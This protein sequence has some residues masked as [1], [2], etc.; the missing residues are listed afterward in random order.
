MIC[1]VD[2]FPKLSTGGVAAGSSG[3]AEGMQAEQT[4]LSSTRAALRYGLGRLKQR[5]PLSA[6]ASEQHVRGG[7]RRRGKRHTASIHT[8]DS[9]SSGARLGRVAS[10]RRHRFA[11]A[12]P[13]KHDEYYRLPR[14][15]R[16]SSMFHLKVQYA[17]GGRRKGKGISSSVVVPTTSDDGNNDESY[18]RNNNQ[19]NRSIVIIAP[20]P[21]ALPTAK[22]DALQ[23]RGQ[24]VGNSTKRDSKD[25]I[26]SGRMGMDVTRPRRA[27]YVSGKAPPHSAPAVTMARAQNV[28]AA[29]GQQQQ[30]QQRGGASSAV[31]LGNNGRPYTV[32][33]VRPSFHYSQR[34]RPLTAAATISPQQATN[35]PQE[36]TAALQPF[37]FS[38][39][40]SSLLSS[41]TSDVHQQHQSLLQ[42]TFHLASPPLGNNN[43]IAAA[44]EAAQQH[45]QANALQTL[46]SGLQRSNT[47]LV[48]DRLSLIL[49]CRYC[50]A[51]HHPGKPKAAV[52]SPCSQC[53]ADPTMVI[54]RRANFVHTSAGPT[55]DIVGYFAAH[56]ANTAAMMAQ[57]Q[58]LGSQTASIPKVSFDSMPDSSM[59]SR[60]SDGSDGSLGS[61]GNML[62]SVVSSAT[63]GSSLMSQGARQAALS[64]S[65]VWY[66]S[67]DAPADS[68]PGMRIRLRQRSLVVPPAPPPT[69]HGPPAEE[70]EHRFDDDPAIPED[71]ADL[72]AE[73]RGTTT[74]DDSG[75]GSSQYHSACSALGD[76][77]RPET[78]DMQQAAAAADI[79]LNTAG[80]LHSR[81]PSSQTHRVFEH[82]QP[83]NTPGY[84]R[85]PSYSAT[86]P[87]REQ[88]PLSPEDA[89]AAATVP[90]PLRE[91]AAVSVSKSNSATTRSTGASNHLLLSGID[92]EFVPSLVFNHHHQRTLSREPQV[93][94]P[95]SC[96][97][98]SSSSFS[99]GIHYQTGSVHYDASGSSYTT[100]PAKA[101]LFQPSLADALSSAFS[102][103]MRAESIYGS[104]PPSPGGIDNGGSTTAGAS[105]E[106][107]A[108]PSKKVPLADVDSQI[109]LHRLSVDPI[110]WDLGRPQTAPGPRTPVGGYRA[111]Q[112]IQPAKPASA[113]GKQCCCGCSCGCASC[114]C[115]CDDHSTESPKEVP[116]S[117]NVW[118]SPRPPS[119]NYCSCTGN[120]SSLASFSPSLR[121]ASSA[122][123]S[124]FTT[125]AKPAA[126]TDNQ[127]SD[128]ISFRTARSSIDSPITSNPMAGGRL[129]PD[130]QFSPTPPKPRPSRLWTAP[131]ALPDRDSHVLPP[132]HMVG[133]NAS[134]AQ[135]SPPING[136]S[137][138]VHQVGTRTRPPR[139]WTAPGAMANRDSRVLP[140]EH[141]VGPQAILRN[142]SSSPPPLSAIAAINAAGK[143]VHH[144]ATTPRP[145]PQE[146]R[147]RLA[148]VPMIDRQ[149]MP[150]PPPPLL[151]LQ[152]P[153][154]RRHS[155]I[156]RTTVGSRGVERKHGADE[157][158]A[159]KN[160]ESGS[161]DEDEE[162][163]VVSLTASAPSLPTRKDGTSA[164]DQANLMQTLF[165]KTD[166]STMDLAAA[167]ATGEKITGAK[168]AISPLSARSVPVVTQAHRARHPV[169]KFGAHAN[170][171]FSGGRHQDAFELYSWALMLL[172]PPE[173]TTPMEMLRRPHA[174]RQLAR[175]GWGGGPMVATADSSPAVSA[176]SPK[177]PVAVES[178]GPAVGE[179]Q[180]DLHTRG[181]AAWHNKL[182]SALG[183]TIGGNGSRDMAENAA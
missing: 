108:Q 160:E 15:L 165:S 14:S 62:A 98:L 152:H 6:G 37:S 111:A 38:P 53:L 93:D 173:G 56:Y 72:G 174:R 178:S 17:N 92:T 130:S 68:L 183:R 128:A 126:D 180:A 105:H 159:Q 36:P 127:V 76:A 12:P 44:M 9:S 114:K 137:S 77:D 123:T 134:G 142:G 146:K 29:A 157:S 153:R 141:M 26:A 74:S 119:S 118:P 138:G 48:N 125:G 117:S 30:Q 144:L 81:M 109:L 21:D 148:P 120:V 94:R 163:P 124:P 168:M 177:S 18:K 101:L 132:E 113:A 63:T 51:V 156:E 139:L 172:N 69:A 158:G 88:A 42:A 45:C 50:A 110:P 5:F 40:L 75:T 90:D 52:T 161:E 71:A 176:L 140:P 100:S 170:D 20:P 11:R 112:T 150:L 46:G 96:S 84:L 135:R 164:S 67:D 32:G 59:G 57:Q 102:S 13:P 107:M 78:G 35:R 181:S 60:S 175:L 3:G 25:I 116:P 97:S 10:K 80:S 2:T 64:G 99:G 61:L 182:S 133:P 167:I 85:I 58:Q 66:D 179:R 147:Q 91:S 23:G 95:L 155:T 19:Q 16:P 70:Q 104:A 166:D 136:D 106:D 33:V 8:V 41:L 86:D 103:P 115:A 145:M 79:T 65:G 28:L 7:R 34:T 83:A 131:G 54:P 1:S 24:A 82:H 151:P 43:H 55:L 49:A 154:H 162:M 129:L 143:I 27:D 87:A 89:A 169:Y 4:A 171:T 149:S 22:Q 47:R 39:S 121:P 122:R 73:R 31:V